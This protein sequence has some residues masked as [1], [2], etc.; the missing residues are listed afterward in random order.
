[1]GTG[2]IVKNNGMKRDFGVMKPLFKGIKDY[3]KVH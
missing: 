2:I 3:S 1:M